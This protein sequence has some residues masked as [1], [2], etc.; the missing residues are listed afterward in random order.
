[1]PRRAANSQRSLPRGDITTCAVANIV[2]AGAVL[3]SLRPI[4]VDW[5]CLDKQTCNKC[6]FSETAAALSLDDASN[7]AWL[8]VIRGVDGPLL[9]AR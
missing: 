3:R 4:S 7:R 5:V 1:M 2:F 9:T 8:V 6:Q